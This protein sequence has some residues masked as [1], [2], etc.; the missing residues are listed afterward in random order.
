MVQQRA[1]T[2]KVGVN[3]VVNVRLSD[4]SS[5]FVRE[6]DSDV[7]SAS[8]S[9]IRLMEDEPHMVGILRVIILSERMSKLMLRYR[10]PPN[11]ICRIL[12]DDEYVSTLGPL[13]VAVCEGEF[14]S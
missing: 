6:V 9:N 4:K 3:L 8:G 14:S 2:L 11:Y 5:E 13:K 12:S 10:V 1:V 7:S